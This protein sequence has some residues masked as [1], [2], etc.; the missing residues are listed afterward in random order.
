MSKVS[1]DT[2]TKIIAEI[3][4]REEDFAKIGD[5]TAKWLKKRGMSKSILLAVPD[6]DYKKIGKYPPVYS[7][8]INKKETNSFNLDVIAMFILAYA[9]SAGLNE[10]QIMEQLSNRIIDMVKLQ[11]KSEEL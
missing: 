1:L 8:V 11:S 10:A 4:E 6:V 9:T 5:I 7:Q 3:I 2:Q